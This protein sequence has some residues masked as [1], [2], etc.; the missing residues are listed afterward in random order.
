MILDTPGIRELQLWDADL[1]QTFADMEEIAAELPVLRLQPRP[2]ARLRDPCGAGRRLVVRR[3]VAVVREAATR[4]RVDRGAAQPPTATGAAPGVQDPRTSESAQ[5]TA[6]RPPRVREDAVELSLPDPDRVYRE[7]LLAQEVARPRLGPPFEWHDGA[8]RLEFERRDVDRMEYLLAIDGR[9]LP[10]PA[11]PRR[12]PGPFG[13]K[14]VVEWP[15]YQPP[16]WLDS[17]ADAGPIERLEIRCRR[18]V[19]RVHVQLYATPDPPGVEAPLLVAHDGP[20]YARVLR[21]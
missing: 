14:S 15:E 7:V 20:E 21:R 8:W 5:E 19:A 1:E 12:A 2:G 13:D 4:A 11:N 17:V 3:T 18:L 16:A 6:L 9:F 10:D